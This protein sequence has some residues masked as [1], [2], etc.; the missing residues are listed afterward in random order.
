M[1]IA[2]DT[3]PT[4]SQHAVRGIGVHTSEL[5]KE[6]KRIKPKNL[7][8]SLVDFSK[9][10]L[11]KYDLVHYQFFHPFFITL[12]FIKPS[13]KMI[14][15]I[16][17]LIPLHYPKYY[18]PGIKGNIKFLIQKSLIKSADGILTISETSKKDIVKRLNIDL[19][20]VHVVYLAPKSIFIKT[21]TTSEIESVK[22]KYN[23]PDKY[24]LY[25]G[26]VNYNKNILTLIKACK[27]VN[28]PLVIVGKNALEIESHEMRLNDIRGPK[29]WIRF[30][31]NLSHPELAHYKYLANEFKTNKN[32]FRLGYISNEDLGGVMKLAT[33]YCQPSFSEGFGL[34][35]LEALASGVPVVASDIPTHKEIYRDGCL[36]A[37]PKEP[38]SFAE[39]F[40]L[41]LNKKDLK[42]KLITEGLK[43]ASEFS[44]E[45]TALKT[46][47][48]YEKV[49]GII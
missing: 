24:V 6:I 8:I 7:D 23:L 5:I 26:D 31:F 28:L 11:S 3:G 41:I 13:K 49:L 21:R 1:K 40:N 19:D 18:P 12:P 4:T 30:I 15:T 14:V 37:D 33:L 45:K 2:I 43:K 10:D 48:L 29:D 36:Y 25:L 47:K 9:T 17:D 32:I 22:K 39:E 34:N 46:I 16:H 27:I 44:W 38:G 35:I 20:N 42:D